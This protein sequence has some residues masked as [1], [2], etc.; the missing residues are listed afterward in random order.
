MAEHR[1]TLEAHLPFRDFRYALRDEY[2]TLRHVTVSGN[3]M[4]DPDGGFLG[5]RGTGRD[6]TAKVV[7]AAEL[8]RPRSVP[9]RRRTCCATRWTACRRAS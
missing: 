2:G 3:P 6:I 9:S 1:A 5:Y 7:A 4:F 8:R